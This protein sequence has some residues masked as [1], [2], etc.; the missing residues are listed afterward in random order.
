MFE[1]WM[2]ELLQ[3]KMDMDTFIHEK[4]KLDDIPRVEWFDIPH[5]QRN[6]GQVQER[7]VLLQD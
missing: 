7:Y 3:E 2:D 1:F 5:V 6:E 4:S